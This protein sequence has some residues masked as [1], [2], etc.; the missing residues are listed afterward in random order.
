MSL[1]SISVIIPTLNE[2]AFLAEAIK[3]CRVEGVTEIIVA[4]GGS[5]DATAA[6]ALE[7]GAQLVV[8]DFAQRAHQMNVGAAQATGDC[9]VFL[10]AD[11]IFELGAVEALRTMLLDKAIIG[12]GFS[13]RFH[14][15][16]PLLPAASSIG[17]LRARHFGIF[18]GD[19]AIWIR[20]ERF[21]EI[22]GFPPKSTFEDVDLSLR[23]KAVGRTRLLTPGITTSSRRFKNGLIRRMVG[24]FFLAFQYLL[25]R[26]WRR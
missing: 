11:S 9:L 22:G 6:I 10:H 24:D 2:E 1:D 26:K 12:G 18:Y 16:M 19:Q 23:M 25:I 5:R 15:S 14:P 7:H 3:S 13:R 4:D 20:R 17:N 8:A 21:V